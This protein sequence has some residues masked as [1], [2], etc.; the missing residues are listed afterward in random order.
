MIHQFMRDIGSYVEKLT[1]RK[2]NG[3]VPRETPNPAPYD[4]ETF[5][6]IV[7]VRRR[8]PAWS[9]FSAG[10]TIHPIRL[11]SDCEELSGRP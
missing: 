9:R 7:G 5:F 4:V 10:K 6:E 2:V 3:T 1:G 8:T 11:C